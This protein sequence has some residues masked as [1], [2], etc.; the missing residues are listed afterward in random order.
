VSSISSVHSPQKVFWEA[1]VYLILG[2][3]ALT[4]T[5]PYTK[6]LDFPSQFS[7]QQ[8]FSLLVSLHSFA[9][10]Q[11]LPFLRV[12]FNAISTWKRVSSFVAANNL[13]ISCSSSP[14]Q[15]LHSI[16]CGFHAPLSPSY[17]LFS[18]PLYLEFQSNCLSGI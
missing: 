6:S 2:L 11:F 15:Y 16:D 18:F 9:C 14:T 5:N 10:P 4:C 3:Y 17:F 12:Y 1:F 13:E 7:I 8:S